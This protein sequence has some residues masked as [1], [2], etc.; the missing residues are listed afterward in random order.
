MINSHQD[1]HIQGGDG[2]KH[3]LTS[4]SR[5]F[6]YKVAELIYENRSPDS[7]PD[8]EKDNP[9]F[10][11]QIRKSNQ[12]RSMLAS[13]NFYGWF[14]IDI[15]LTNPDI[16]VE[17]WHLMQ[18]PSSENYKPPGNPTQNE[19][20]IQAYRQMSQIIRSIYAILNCLPAK[21]LSMHLKQLPTNTR[22]FKAVCEPF[23]ILPA[24]NEEYTTYETARSMFGPVTTPVGRTVIFLNHRISLEE[25]LPRPIVSPHQ[26]ISESPIQIDLFSSEQDP[27]FPE[28][29]APSSLVTAATNFSNTPALSSFTQADYM[30]YQ[31]QT[32]SENPSLQSS[33]PSTSSNVEQMD[34]SDLIRLIQENMNNDFDEAP[35]LESIKERFDVVKTTTI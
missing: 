30:P 8:L 24:N 4:L 7:L 28:N 5:M 34:A 12:L 19:L 10:S 25:E 11:L 16:V 9:L 3:K 6:L 35:T 29:E 14:K 31:T 26:W 2:S 1:G 22:K 27:P 23:Q 32:N 15:I 21:T 18:L 17:R 13:K 20:K 33:G